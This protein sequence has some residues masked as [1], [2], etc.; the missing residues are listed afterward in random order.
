MWV[1]MSDGR[2][3]GCA[4][5]DVT[6]V[7][8]TLIYRRW[9]AMRRD[10]LLHKWYESEK[11]GYDIGWDRAVIDWMIKHGSIGTTEEAR[12]TNTP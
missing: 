7:R 11:A 3:Y 10:I 8:N 12:D 5:S 2:Q 6:W 4:D 9:E 1:C